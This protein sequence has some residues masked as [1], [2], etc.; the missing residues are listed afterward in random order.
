MFSLQDGQSAGLDRPRKVASIESLKSF[1][2]L[3][4]VRL[5]KLYM[6]ELWDK[7]RVHILR[8]SQIVDRH[9]YRGR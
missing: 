6:T 2:K 5:G 8:E 3:A 9:K 7:R 4:G 1:W